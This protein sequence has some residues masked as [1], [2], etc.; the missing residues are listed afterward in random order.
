MSRTKKNKK[1]HKKTTKSRKKLFFFLFFLILIIS[2]LGI[3]YLNTKTII[4]HE[5]P[6]T[7]SNLP[8]ENHGFKIVHFSDLHFGTS[9]R[10][11][12]IKRLVERINRNN[13]DLII[14]TGDLIDSSL[15]RTEE[16]LL[17]SALKELNPT[18]GTYA[19]LGDEDDERVKAIFEEANIILLE[20]ELVEIFSKSNTPLFLYGLTYIDPNFDELIYNL[21]LVND[22]V[23]ILLTHHPD[24]FNK[25]PDVNIDLVL[26][27]H[28]HNGQINLP[29]INLFNRIDQ[30]IIYS[31]PFNQVDNTKIFTS[32]GIGT[33]Y[34]PIRIGTGASFNLYRLL[35]E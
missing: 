26:A 33:K 24:Y 3:T 34:I 9:F 19:V 18:I 2:T 27:G 16:E 5:H 32:A 10:G 11:N 15:T 13:P 4:V 29:F 22:H 23:L 20:N 8:S 7:L 30:D 12:D 25:A 17:I 28:S 21:E 31:R 6:I 1:L 35:S 14:F